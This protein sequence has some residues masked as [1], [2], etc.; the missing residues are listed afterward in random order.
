MHCTPKDLVILFKNNHSQFARTSPPSPQFRSVTVFFSRSTKNSLFSAQY[1]YFFSRLKIYLELL[2]SDPIEK[3][4]VFSRIL[5]ETEIQNVLETK[6]NRVR[7]PLDD[8]RR[9]G[10]EAADRL[11]H[12]TGGQSHLNLFSFVADG[13]IVFATGKLN[14]CSEDEEQRTQMGAP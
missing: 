13:Q 5:T 10:V 6:F 1:I 2:G 7:N 11:G 9:Q 12:K 8:Q 4:L 14:I 3:S